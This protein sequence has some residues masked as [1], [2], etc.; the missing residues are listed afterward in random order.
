MLIDSGVDNSKHTFPIAIGHKGKYNNKS[1]NYCIK[2][3]KEMYSPNNKYKFYCK[4]SNK[5]VKVSIFLDAIVIDTIEKQPHNNYLEG[6]STFDLLC[7]YSY[8]FKG[9]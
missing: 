4:N 8:N 9:I 7:S 6:T 3:L 2:E 1:D 5:Y